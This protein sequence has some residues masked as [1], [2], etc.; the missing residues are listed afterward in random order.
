MIEKLSIWLIR[1][2]SIGLKTS[3][4]SSKWLNPPELLGH[5]IWLR[6]THWMPSGSSV[7]LCYPSLPSRVLQTAVCHALSLGRKRQHSWLFFWCKVILKLRFGPK[8]A[9]QNL[10]C[11]LLRRFWHGQ[12]W[13]LKAEVRAKMQKWQSAQGGA[14]GAQQ[15]QTWLYPGPPGSSWRRVFPGCGEL[16]SGLCSSP[17]CA[18][19]MSNTK[20]QEFEIYWLQID[21]GS[22]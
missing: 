12:V 4:Q 11:P 18:K 17:P 22:T 9:Q 10:H 1:D 21:V 7:G 2:A 13:Y 15:L 20:G 6:N 8:R 19:I 14:Q 5:R 3:R 16:V